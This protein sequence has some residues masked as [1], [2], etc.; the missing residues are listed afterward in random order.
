MMA[1]LVNNLKIVLNMYSLFRLFS[2]LN[3]A[4]VT[5]ENLRI[6]QNIS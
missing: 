4:F 3:Q 5:H 1:A 2:G 6:A